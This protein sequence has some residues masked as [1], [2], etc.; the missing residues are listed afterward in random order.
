M[1]GEPSTHHTNVGRASSRPHSLAAASPPVCISPRSHTVCSQSVNQSIGQPH[2][3][4]SPCG[5]PSSR[6]MPTRWVQVSICPCRQP[7]PKSGSRRLVPDQKSNFHRRLPNENPR[8]KQRPSR[9][10]DAVGRRRADLTA[11]QSRAAAARANI[12]R[13]CHDPALVETQRLDL[14]PSST[15]SSSGQTSLA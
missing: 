6:R 4:P 2:R 12:T 15:Q 5:Q 7:E 9:D 1:T 14:P 3:I 10:Q 13:V 11:Q 8:R